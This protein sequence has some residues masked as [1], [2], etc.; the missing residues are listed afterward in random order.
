M[1]HGF[2]GRAE[3]EDRIRQAAER[4][5]TLDSNLS[6]PHTAL[7]YVE[8]DVSRAEPHFRR[9]IALNP[10]DATA[11]VGLARILTLT[12]RPREALDAANAAVELDPISGMYRA[13]RGLVSY[14]MR[15]FDAAEADFLEAIRMSP[16]L[17]VGAVCLRRLYEATGRWDEALAILPRSIGPRAP[18]SLVQQEQLI[19]G[20]ANP[21][22][23]EAA[24]QLLDRL[25]EEG[26]APLVALAIIAIQLGERSMALDLVERAHVAGDFLNGFAIDP[27]VDSLRNEPR[28]RAVL[29]A[30][31]VPVN[32]G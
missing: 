2:I 5:L 1:A 7:A 4:A 14:S 23:R 27:Q 28:F 32:G 17:K 15:A 30:A 9:A 31:G 29:A 25:V 24:V 21:E 13:W 26:A 11:Y 19:R 20:M 22:H 16:E 6:D 18:V 12:A 8:R 10:R 3:V